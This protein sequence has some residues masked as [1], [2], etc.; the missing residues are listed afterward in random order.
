VYFDWNEIRVTTVTELAEALAGVPEPAAAAQ[1]VKRALQSVFEMHYAFD[2]EPLK[3][4]NLGK[5][6]K[7]MEKIQGSTPFVRSYVAQNALE[8][9]SIPIGKA[10]IDLLHALGVISDVEADK[11]Q[12]PGLERA[13]PKNKGIEFGSLLHQAAA[14]LV[15]SPGSSKLKSMLAEIDPD[16]KERLAARQA[17]QEAAAAAAA[18][19]A[20]ER[21]QEA[22]AAAIAAREAAAAEARA[23]AEKAAAKNARARDKSKR[24]AQAQPP[25]PTPPPLAAKDKPKEKEKEAAK[26]KPTPPA[27]SKGSGDKHEHAKKSPTKGLAKKKPR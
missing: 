9:H 22:R 14:D 12:S 23:A 2:L 7:D 26:S 1:R 21:R 8:G 27:A 11:G 10:E 16:Y 3:K 18:E 13:I 4:Q 5:S 17:K 25:A 19:V 6:E 20:K 15:A 24:A